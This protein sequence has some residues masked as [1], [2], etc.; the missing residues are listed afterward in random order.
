MKYDHQQQNV[1]AFNTS[2]PIVTAA[3]AISGPFSFMNLF[4]FTL[5]LPLLCDGAAFLSELSLAGLKSA[6]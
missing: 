1:T 3:L 5:E 6:R 2:T 4:A